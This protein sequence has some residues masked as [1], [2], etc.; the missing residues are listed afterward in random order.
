MYLSCC[1]FVV[2]LRRM[3]MYLCLAYMRHDK[4]WT[5]Y[6]GVLAFLYPY[7][8]LSFFLLLLLAFSSTRFVLNTQSNIN[9]VYQT[10]VDSF[11]DRLLQSK[12]NHS[13]FPLNRT[14]I[15]CSHAQRDKMKRP[16]PHHIENDVHRHASSLS[17]ERRLRFVK[18][19]LLDK[20]IFVFTLENCLS[21]V[22][23]RD[24]LII[25]VHNEVFALQERICAE[26][27]VCFA[28]TSHHLTDDRQET[29]SSS[30]RIAT[31]HC[32][33]FR[34]APCMVN[35]QIETWLQC[36]V[37]YSTTEEDSRHFIINQFTRPERRQNITTI[38]LEER[39][40]VS[41]INQTL[42]S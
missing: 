21:F 7:R 20:Y 9:T 32:F 12:A 28:S 24:L 41:M 1:L 31:L 6:G 13:L 36:C 17:T 10:I 33:Y 27:T 11:I 8:L 42:P 26:A 14:T 37:E 40:N 25:K 4:R 39:W 30:E 38:L 23:V 16:H 3:G 34:S 19:K 29:V 22:V 5:S 2:F 35:T 18:R 15:I